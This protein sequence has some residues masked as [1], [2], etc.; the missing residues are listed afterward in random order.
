[1]WGTL[2]VGAFPP[3]GS[4]GRGGADPEVCSTGGMICRF[5]DSGAWFEETNFDL[6]HTVTAR[7]V[8][9]GGGG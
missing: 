2:G 5:F 8:W 4:A 3:G 7:P 6:T 9:Y 1:V